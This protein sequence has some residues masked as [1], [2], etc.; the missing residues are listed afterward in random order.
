MKKIYIIED[1]SDISNLYTMLFD[2]EGIEIEGVVSSGKTAIE[3]IE[4]F[5][6]KIHDIVFIIDIRIPEKS[7]I[8]VVRKLLEI[9]PDIKNQIIIATADDRITKKEITDLGIPYFLR[10]PFSLD[11]LL[12]TIEEIQK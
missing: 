5:K 11:E 7:G 12:Q 3:N 1:E 4:Q 9:A 2:R 10:K 6:E 8:E